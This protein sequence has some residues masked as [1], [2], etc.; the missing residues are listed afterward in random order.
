MSKRGYLQISFGWLFAIIAGIVILFL[1]I[2][3]SMKIIDRGTTTVDSKTTKE[4]EIL[5]NPLETGFESEKTTTLTLPSGTRIN[6][7]CDNYGEFGTQKLSV[8]QKSFNKYVDS[9]ISNEFYNKYIFSEEYVEGK[10]FYISSLTFDMPFK[11]ADLILITSNK[12]CFLDIPEEV[13]EII[14]F[15]ENIITN[16]E[17]CSD[18][19]IRVCFSRYKQNC[20]IFVDY[21]NKYVEKNEERMY[22]EDRL[23]FAAIFSQK[24]IYECQVKR[25]MQRAEKLYS[26]YYNKANFIEDKCSNELS[27]DLISM[28]NN[29][30][31]F[32]DSRDLEMIKTNAEILYEKNKWGDCSLW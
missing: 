21:Y 30:K 7:Q 23:L 15:Q 13:E 32:E 29:A 12:Y 9:G 4:I 22:F 2:Y 26:L 17:E 6:N 16:E 18:K 14:P 10:K 20:D 19:D 3:L 24:N 11:I 5:L 8:S 25:I 31:N 27:F 1:A 28:E